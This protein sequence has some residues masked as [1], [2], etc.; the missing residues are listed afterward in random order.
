MSSRPRI[1]VWRRW[2]DGWIACFTIA[3]IVW[4]SF[5]LLPQLLRR[6]FAGLSPPWGDVGYSVVMLLFG[7]MLFPVW[8]SSILAESYPR[9]LENL[10]GPAVNTGPKGGCDEEAA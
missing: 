1:P 3:P 8:I 2:V 10:W 6:L 4:V 7:G 9:M 5:I